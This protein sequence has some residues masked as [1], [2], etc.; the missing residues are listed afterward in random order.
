MEVHVCHLSVNTQT[1]T[2]SLMNSQCQVQFLN[3]LCSV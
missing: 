2:L 3:L 1:H